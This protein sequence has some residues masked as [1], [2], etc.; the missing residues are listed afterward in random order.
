MV[1]E[2]EQE[3]EREKFREFLMDSVA[4]SFEI[5]KKGW[6][7]DLK[8]LLPLKRDKCAIKLVSKSKKKCSILAYLR[9]CDIVFGK[10][11]NWRHS[12]MRVARVL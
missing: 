12:C 4:G 1:T 6:L 5:S 11:R 10:S 2:Q 7:K 9:K 8:V 3:W